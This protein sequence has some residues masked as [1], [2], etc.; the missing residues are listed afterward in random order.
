MGAV[1]LKIQNH[2]SPYENAELA[3]HAEEHGLASIWVSEFRWEP[4]VP[5]AVF[6]AATERIRVGSAISPVY[7]RSAPVL[8]MTAANLA[9]I[10]PGRVALGLGTSTE[11]IVEEWHGR[12][13]QRP[14][15]AAREY[16]EAVR[17]ILAGGEVTYAGEVVSFERFVLEPAALAAPDTEIHLAA[18]GERM[19]AVAGAVAD[20]AL[21]NMTPFEHLPRIREVVDAASVA[22]GRP[23]GSVRLGGDLS[24]A[25]AEGAERDRLRAAQRRS[26][27]AYAQMGPY[28]RFF[29]EAG[30]DPAVIDDAMVDSIALIGDAGYVR[31]GLQRAFDLGLDEAIAVPL[32]SEDADVAAA[33]RA[34]VEEIA[35]V[36]APA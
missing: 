30:Y 8:A 7:A 15:T 21:L 9:Q 31:E 16:V 13:R 23:A 19:L 20:G 32:W 10:A 18:L 33:T 6:A 4:F 14:L 5:L 28:A 26:I 1:G 25:V 27:E 34:V 29:A 2:L 11:E 36:G 22:A 12:A 24:I 17:Q 35:S 3:A